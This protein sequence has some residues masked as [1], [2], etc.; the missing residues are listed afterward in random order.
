MDQRVETDPPAPADRLAERR[1]DH[2]ADHWA[3]RPAD[4]PST[5]PGMPLDMPTQTFR[6]MVRAQVRTRGRPWT[7]TFIAR[8]VVFGGALLLT[9]LA[10]RQMALA[11]A[12]GEVTALQALLV[13]IFTVTFWWI[14][15]S[16]TS[17]L[18][19]LLRSLQP[20][21]GS[22]T[23]LPQEAPGLCALV[24][25]VYNEDPAATTGAL[26]AI[27]EDLERTGAA[28]GFEIFILSDTT[29]PTVWV[30]ETAA[31]V[32][33]R[34]RLGST[35]KVWYRHRA[36]NIDRKSGN[37]HD[38]VTRWGGRYE[39]ML[40]LDAD[41]LMTAASI[42]ALRERM[43]A[44]PALGLVQTVPVLIGRDSLF[45]RMQQFAGRIYGPIV[46]RGVAAWQG[47]DGNFWGH[48]AIIRTQAFAQACGLPRLP[49]RKP[50]GGTI[51][52][53]DFVEAAL[54]RRAGWAV[55]MA[56]EIGGSWESSPPSLLDFAMRDRRWAQ[57]NIQHLAVIGARGL[58]W[59]SRMHLLNGVMSY[60]SS[61]LWF[62]LILVGVGLTVQAYLLR[63]K[64][65]TEA[66]QL[67]PTW[68]RF[69]S[70]RMILLF[71]L[72]IGA[73]LVPKIIG[74]LR[75]MIDRSVVKSFGDAR[76]LV[77]GWIFEVLLSALFAPI[78]MLIQSRHV[79]SILR[80]TDSGWGPQRRDDG[81]MGLREA[82]R[83]HLGHTALGLVVVAAIAPLS[84]P[85]LAWLSPVLAGW[86]LS[87]PLSWG[88]GSAWLGR[89]LAALGILVIPEE[90]EIPALVTAARTEREAAE[91]DLAEVSLGRLLGDPAL[92]DRHFALAGDHWLAERGHPDVEML[93][94]A[95][96]VADARTRAEALGWLRPVERMRLLGDRRT[97]DTLLSLPA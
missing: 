11:V 86:I 28:G 24:M 92:A 89:K 10:A 32:R 17:A 59:P 12:V 88:S 97:F 74:L 27:A 69:D 25:P 49:G 55:Q 87:I 18:A 8:L 21:A 56:P 47:D 14:S 67:F 57:G 75:A 9:A 7:A 79:W 1:A 80:G 93:T 65:F 60:L 31:V 45:A 30:V 61:P 20:S 83:F 19:G 34:E 4:Y 26:A 91:A 33:L 54:L 23:A 16:T 77:V 41:S 2:W 63:P 58:R 64:Y 38:F 78:M 62:A 35:M 5:P 72:T 37:I 29:D 36:R 51:M 94:A 95:A 71:V 22:G 66:F 73:L 6:R 53:H 76:R 44:D 15:M 39:T 96:K 40:V 70:E 85:V 48:N 50:F 82:V 84:M 3:D 68:P 90:R 42:L 81:G 43:A 13:A 52:S 46:A